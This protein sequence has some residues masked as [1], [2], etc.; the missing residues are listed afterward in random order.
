MSVADPK[1]PTVGDV[2]STQGQAAVRPVEPLL[3]T[4]AHAAI[5]LGLGRSKIY[6]LMGQGLLPFILI[7]TARRIPVAAIEDFIENALQKQGFLP[8]RQL[9]VRRGSIRS[10]E[11][12]P[13][14]GTHARQED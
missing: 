13:Q 10:V 1:R 7:G 14:G 5:A 2:E 8:T 9:S 3:L 6:E 11:S 12:A 4:P